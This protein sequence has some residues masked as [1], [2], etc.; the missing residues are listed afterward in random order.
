MEEDIYMDY[1]MQIR[2]AV[3][4]EEAKKLMRD[5]IRENRSQAYEMGLEEG[6]Y[7]LGHGWD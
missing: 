3:T 2:R 1:V 7:P 6:K 5:I 4:C